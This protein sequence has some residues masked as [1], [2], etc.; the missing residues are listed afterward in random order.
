MTGRSLRDV[1]PVRR[2]PVILAQSSSLSQHRQKVVMTTL[3]DSNKLY[4]EAVYFI[5]VYQ[6]RIKYGKRT[7]LRLI[8]VKTENSM[9]YLC[10]P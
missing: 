9:Y 3:A 6:L 2:L 1:T 5:E 10:I 4:R 7:G 8:K